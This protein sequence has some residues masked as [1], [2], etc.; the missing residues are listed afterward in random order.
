MAAHLGVFVAAAQI[1][2]IT[3]LSKSLT[4]DSQGWPWGM[5]INL[6]ST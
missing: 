3:F 2:Q 6:R 4:L 5:G 1:L